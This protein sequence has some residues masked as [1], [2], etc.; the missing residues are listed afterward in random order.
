MGWGC[1]TGLYR[2]TVKTY[3]GS[4]MGACGSPLTCFWF[5]KVRVASYSSQCAMQVDKLSFLSRTIQEPY[6]LLQR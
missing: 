2:Q 5:L 6:L 3:T 1:A 4:G